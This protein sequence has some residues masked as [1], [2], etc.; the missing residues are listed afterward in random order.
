METFLELPNEIPSHGTF[1]RVFALLDAEQLEHRLMDWVSAVGEL[2]KGNS[3][4]NLSILV[5]LAMNL[6]KQDKSVNVRIG[7]KRKNGQVG[8]KCICLRSSLHNMRLP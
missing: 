6:L 2:T 4:E 7:A 5:R 1:G 3:A 8:T